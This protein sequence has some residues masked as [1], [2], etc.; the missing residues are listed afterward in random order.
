MKYVNRV[1]R[2][3]GTIQL[4]L[5][6]RGLPAVRLPDDLPPRALEQHVARLIRDLVP[7]GTGAL[8]G[9][10]A[11]AVRVYELESPEFRAL[12]K[13][14]QYEYRLILKEFD[15][16]L[17]SVAISAFTPAFVDRLKTSWAKRGYRA[18]NLRLQ[19]LKN[20]LKPCLV[21]GLLEKDPFPLVGQVR[22][23]R[24]L[25]EPH[26]I[27]S[28]EMFEVVAQAA[29]DAG[30]PGLARAL[31]IARYVGARRG[32]L[33]AIPRTAR[34]NGRFRFMSGKRRVRV[35]VAEDPQLTRWLERTPDAPEQR[36]R[37]GRKVPPGAE[38]AA[39]TTIVYNVAGRPYT[40]DGLALELR[41]LLARLHAQGRI[42][43]DRY[44]LHGLRHTCGVELALAGCSDAEGAAMMGHGSPSSFVQYRRQAD[45]V[46]LADAAA[47]RVAALREQRS[48]KKCNGECNK[49][50]TRPTW[51][52]KGP[53]NFP[54]PS[55]PYDGTASPDRTEDLQSHN[56]A[57]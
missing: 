43:S 18:A 17:G 52:E 38:P 35:D 28:D 40:E 44:D 47:T 11:A 46:R 50:A 21:S 2:P 32:D 6:K 39:T 3:D 45:R 8:R 54:V 14:T 26:L 56:L 23:P 29:L 51:N 13:S 41:K 5:R 36:P 9:T 4:Y 53:G 42:D 7:G 34:Q 27:W 12:A 19:V 57:L 15:E 24:A 49:S 48:N 37:R 10:L 16:D 22:R 1:Q 33:V 55:R 31:A 20:V 30:K 25:R